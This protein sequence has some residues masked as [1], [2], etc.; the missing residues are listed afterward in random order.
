[1]RLLWSCHDR[2][3]G[4]KR[5]K[6]GLGRGGRAAERKQQVKQILPC[7]KQEISEALAR[8]EDENRS[9][10]REIEVSLLSDEG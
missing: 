1:M 10:S 8:K 3:V 7:C 9:H 5:L 4:N 6:A 2:T